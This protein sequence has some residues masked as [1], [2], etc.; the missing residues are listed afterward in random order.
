[1]HDPNAV[2]FWIV[3]E[4]KPSHAFDCEGV[5][6]NLASMGLDQAHDRIKVIDAYGAF[7][8]SHARSAQG[9]LTVL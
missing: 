4:E 5:G 8:T 2:F 9:F 6:D 1:L 3:H 7:E